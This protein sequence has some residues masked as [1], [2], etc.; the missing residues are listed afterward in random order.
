[1]GCWQSKL[2]KDLHLLL[3]QIEEMFTW[4]WQMPGI[5]VLVSN[6]CCC[7]VGDMFPMLTRRTEWL[8]RRK[9]K[10]REGI[11]SAVEM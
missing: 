11:S 8:I 6:L 1:M 5:F 3:Q 2:E 9:T 10:S 4:L 7:H